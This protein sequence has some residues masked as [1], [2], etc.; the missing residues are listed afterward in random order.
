MTDMKDLIGRVFT[1]IGF[2]VMVFLPLIILI[3]GLISLFKHGSDMSSSE[4]LL[5]LI[6]IGLKDGISILLGV[7]IILTGGIIAV[8]NPI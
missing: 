8:S 4:I 7:I 5:E 3:T 1:I 6:I 2:V